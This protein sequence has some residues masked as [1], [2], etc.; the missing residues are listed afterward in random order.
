MLKRQWFK[1]L[2]GTS[3]VEADT[4]AGRPIKNNKTVGWISSQASLHG[5]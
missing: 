4:R 2:E 3:G 5:P 1:K